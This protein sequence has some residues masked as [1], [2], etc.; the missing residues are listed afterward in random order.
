[1][2][3]LRSPLSYRN[4][5]Q[6]GA[7]RSKVHQLNI[8]F[9]E[10]KRHFISILCNTEKAYLPWR[11]PLYAPSWGSQSHQSATV[12][13]PITNYMATGLISTLGFFL[14]L[15]IKS[16]KII[17]DQRCLPES[18]SIQSPLG[19]TDPESAAPLGL[20]DSEVISES[21]KEE[22]LYCDSYYLMLGISHKGTVI[23]G[24]NLSTDRLHVIHMSYFFL[25][26]FLWVNRKTQYY[27]I[28]FNPQTE[29]RGQ[30]DPGGLIC[31]VF[32]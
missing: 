14:W 20:K 21:K 16:S 2:P 3:Y 15:P 10:D 23:T 9:C 24:S 4:G 12:R 8:F 32:Q 19:A 17:L 29:I 18:R 28:I 31:A 5:C 11:T 7:F 26:H 30:F 25:S 1:M 22:G 13:T 27:L 6:I